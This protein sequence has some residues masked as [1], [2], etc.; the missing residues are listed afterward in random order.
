M[1]NNKNEIPFESPMGRI[2]QGSA[3][4]GQTHDLNNVLLTPFKSGPDAGKPRRNWFIGLA[5]PKNSPEWAAFEAKVIELAQTHPQYLING[6]VNPRFSL[7]IR[8]G[9]DAT[10]NQ[11]GTRNV[12]RE[13]FAGSNILAFSTSYAPEVVG[14]YDQ[15]TGSCPAFSRNE[16]YMAQGA[17]HGLPGDWVV[18]RGT[19]AINNNAQNPGIYLNM[20]MIMHCYEDVRIRPQE[21][22]TEAFRDYKMPARPPAV[23]AP[24]QQG[25]QPPQQTHQEPAPGSYQPP[26][27]VPVAPGGYQPP[28][29]QGYQPPQRPHQAQRQGF[30]GGPNP[31]DIPF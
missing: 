9:D 28:A 22:A 20:K 10:P 31:D 4:V 25:Y 13:G 15:T 26:P 29:Q 3:Y 2:V 19:M 18:V 5:V 24:M 30:A 17:N 23:A 12:D 7:K 11:N 27:P 14:P 6:A 16:S 21:T 8:D 1:S